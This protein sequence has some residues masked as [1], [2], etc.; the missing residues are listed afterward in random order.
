MSVHEQGTVATYSPR[1]AERTMPAGEL[2][3]KCLRV[4]DEVAQTRGTS[5]RFRRE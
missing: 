1:D 2:K 5:P 4:L 3:A